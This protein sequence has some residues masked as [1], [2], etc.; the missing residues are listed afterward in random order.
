VADPLHPVDVDRDCWLMRV[1]REVE[2]PEPELTPRE[3]R[4]CSLVWRVT[5]AWFGLEIV[6][7]GIAI[8]LLWES[9]HG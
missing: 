9:F 2:A 4:I 3:R 7:V 5:I 8:V 6:A 1:Q